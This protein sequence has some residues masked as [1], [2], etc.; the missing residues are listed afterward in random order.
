MS[1]SLTKRSDA[2]TPSKRQTIVDTAAG[3]FSR[4]G[5]RAVGIDRIIAESGVAK[6]TLY[7]HF[8]QK[9]DLILEVIQK[10]SDEYRAS[11]SEK[12]ARRQTPVD[13][14]KAIFDWHHDWIQRPDFA[15]C[16]FTRASSEFDGEDD[17]IRAAAAE[18]KAYL[19]TIFQPLLKQ[20]GLTLRSARQLSL[21]LSFL[22]DGAVVSALV[23]G[24]R[25]SA[26]EAWQVAEALIN[27]ELKSRAV[28]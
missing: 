13:K 24:N 1:L 18:H 17:A 7:R 22:I 26:K 20:S 25:S 2:G 27:C 4:H 19:R 10:K 23:I 6:M 28:N 9:N 15:G 8:P 14:I 3:L 21:A 11:L 16:L 12:M 5:Y